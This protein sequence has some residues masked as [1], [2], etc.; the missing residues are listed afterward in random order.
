MKAALIAIAVTGLAAAPAF[1]APFALTV[2]ECAAV[3]AFIAACLP[4][5]G[6]DR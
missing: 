5:S 1:R 3:A 2:A 4:W 6:S